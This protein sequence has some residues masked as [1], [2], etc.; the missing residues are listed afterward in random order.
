MQRNVSEEALCSRSILH[1]GG[2]SWFQS[3]S[4]GVWESIDQQWQDWSRT[5]VWPRLVTVHA[6]LKKLIGGPWTS[7][8][9][10]VE[11]CLTLWTGTTSTRSLHFQSCAQRLQQSFE[12]I[13]KSPIWRCTCHIMLVAQILLGAEILLNAWLSLWYVAL[14]KPYLM[15]WHS[16]CGLPLHTEIPILEFV[17]GIDATMVNKCFL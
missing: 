7:S 1:L 12:S 14:F 8:E 15:N 9:R 10:P 5:F 13:Q 3:S 17:K 2:E 4:T 16:F 6:L 11:H